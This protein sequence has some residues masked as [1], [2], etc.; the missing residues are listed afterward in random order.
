MEVKEEEEVVWGRKVPGAAL[1]QGGEP[2][3]FLCRGK[4]YEDS[5][6]TEAEN[7]TLELGILRRF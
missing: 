3:C 7:A 5:V 4:Q 6:C 1:E 2:I